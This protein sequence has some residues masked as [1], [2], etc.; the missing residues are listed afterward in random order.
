MIGSSL[1]R[2]AHR[3]VQIITS[4]GAL[5]IRMVWQ[6]AESSR[7]LLA[8]ERWQFQGSAKFKIRS[9]IRS[10][11]SD[12]SPVSACTH[13]C[14]RR[15]LQLMDQVIL[16]SHNIKLSPLQAKVLWGHRERT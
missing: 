12:T 2:V 3:S 15:L 8:V 16:G 1:D 4:A 7:L 6:L 9:D 5:L 11:L 14:C 10:E 13:S